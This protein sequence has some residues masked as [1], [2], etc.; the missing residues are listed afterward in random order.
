[1]ASGNN[2]GKNRM[3]KI[4]DDMIRNGS[5]RMGSDDWKTYVADAIAIEP[6]QRTPTQREQIKIAMERKNYPAR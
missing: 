2:I 1:M 4:T 6:A 5:V 3:A